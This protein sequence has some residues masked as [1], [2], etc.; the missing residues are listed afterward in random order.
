M[1]YAVFFRNVNLGRA[2]CPSKMELE[3]AFISAGADSPSSFLVNGTLVYSAP[4]HDVAH[5]VLIDACRQLQD[6]CGLREPAFLR[7][8]DS[9]ERLVAMNP[10]AAVEKST[11]FERCISFLYS[12][13]LDLP[14]TPL[15][16]KRSD[17]QILQFTKAEVFSVSR[18]IGK[19]PG[20]PNAFLEKLLVSPVTTRNWNTVCRLLDK[21][22]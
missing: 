13:A 5:R 14:A 11:V 2:Y 15:E 17:V 6:Q 12:D 3:Q 8:L 18:L 21:H 7:D 1:K 10:F 22:A 4:D 20:S 16:S 19:S 9:L